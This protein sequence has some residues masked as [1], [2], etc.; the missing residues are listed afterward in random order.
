MANTDLN[1]Q[2]AGTGAQNID[3]SQYTTWVPIT[4][5]TGQIVYE[6]PGSGYVYD[7]FKS[8]A[9]G[10]PVLYNHPKPQL[11]AKA[12]QQKAIDDA[13]KA[14]SPATQLGMLGGATAVTVAAPKIV[15]ALTPATATGGAVMTPQG[16]GV[17][18]SDGTVKL[19]GAAAGAAPST[20]AGAFTQAATTPIVA[21][22][23]TGQML[24]T[25]PELA[26]VQS[27]GNVPPLETFGAESG[28]LAPTAPTGFMSTP[29]ESLGGYTPGQALGAVGALKGG[30]DTIQGFQ[31]G[32][33]GMRTGMTETG[34]GIGMMVGGPIGSFIGAA[35]G[36]VLGYGAKK[37]GLYH[38]TT[39][40]NRA[41]HTNQLIKED[42]N[43]PNWVGYVNA[44][45]N[46]QPVDK[47]KP[48]AGQYS[49]WEEYKKAGLD[50]NDLT[51]VYGNLN[52]FGKEWVTYSQPQRVAITQAL[53]DNNL[54]DS[55]KGEVLVTDAEKAKQLK[56]QVIAGKYTPSATGAPVV[57]T[58]ETARSSTSSPGIS[59]TGQRIYYT[60][61][62]KQLANRMNRR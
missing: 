35:A 56:D 47:S 15:D 14:N 38:E 25:A 55:K 50:A 46:N 6:V 33:T 39:A 23:A 27:F 44:M 60:D 52:T 36:N 62:G 54:Y 12:Q 29:M 3:Y 19:A 20:A 57:T 26:G 40:Q 11:D 51:G 2:A 48:F 17:I 16:V 43:D 31:H 41:K 18:M 53:I 7:P 21:N 5:S 42:P 30:Y 28:G 10:R 32:G 37:F 4:L 24:G 58:P 34:A 9:M 59:K 45:R 22:P 13:K 8:Q 49:T 61:T 1:K